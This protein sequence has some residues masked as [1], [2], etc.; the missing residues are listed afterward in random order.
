MSKVKSKSVP[1]T[2]SKPGVLSKVKSGAVM[3]PAQS[4][5]AKSKVIA[6][7][8]ATKEQKKDKKNKK[9]PVKEPTPE[10]ESSSEEESE[11]SASSEEDSETEEEAKPNGVNGVK[12]HEEDDSEED[13]SDES[14]SEASSEDE[15]PKVNGSAPKTKPAASDSEEEDDDESSEEESDEEETP[16]TTGAKKGRAAVEEEDDDEESSDESDSDE[17]TAGPKTTKATKANGVK[18]AESSDEEAEDSDESSDESDESEVSEDEEAEAKPAKRKAE[19]AEAPAAKKTKVEEDGSRGSNLFVGNLSWNVDEE[20][21]K[22]E[23]EEFGELSGVRLITQRED[24]RSKGYGYV[25]FVNAAD[26]AKAHAAKQGYELDGRVMNV[27]FANKKPDSGEKQEKRR[28]SYGDQLSEPSDTLFLGNLSFEITEDDVYNIFAPYGAPTGVRIP[29]DKETGNVKGYGYVTFATLEEAKSALEGA[30]GSYVKN[31][32]MRVDYAQPRQQNSDSPARGGGFGGFGGR[33]G[34]GGPRGGRGGGR[35][36]GG[37]GGRG[38]RGGPRGGARGGRGGTT[39]RGGFG[40]F[41][42]KKTTF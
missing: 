36:F 27:D 15:A 3:K 2:G 13:S 4:V 10:P 34:R 1:T 24:G 16:T 8:V 20:W 19:D 38:G 9:V 31:R 30:Q 6:K 21:L 23:F 25:E 42:G 5:K 26:A 35:D 33:G 18:A 12:V 29:T 28:Q 32:P 11:D 37:R 39:N 40:D 41:S 14:D 7:E 17:E 22:S